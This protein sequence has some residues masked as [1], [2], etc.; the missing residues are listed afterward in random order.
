MNIPP[1]KN[2]PLYVCI[3]WH[4][5]QP[6]YKKPDSNEYIMPWVRLHAIKDYYDMLYEVLKYPE[7]KVTFN[8][9][10]SL[11]QQIKDYAENNVED[12]F[13]SVSKKEASLLTEDEKIFILKNFFS[14]NK[15]SM[16]EPYSRYKWLYEKRGID[17]T[18][19]VLKDKLK[20]FNVND[21]RDLQVW[22]NLAW[23]GNYLKSKN[24]IKNLL[25]K[26]RNFSESDKKIL[27]SE[28]E[29]LIGEIL[30]LYKKAFQ[31]NRI[32]ISTSPYF[33]P[34]LPLLFDIN[35]ARDSL[36]NVELPGQSF[37]YPEDAIYQVESA[38][39]CF[40][41]EFGKR[42]DG[43][44]PSEG[45]ISEE[46]LKILEDKGFKWV[47][48]DETV[49]KNS[50]VKSGI[51]RSEDKLLHQSKYIPY[52][53]KNASGI[54][55]FF[56]DLLLSDMV[57]FT[58]S[59]YNGKRAADDL[60]SRLLLIRKNLPE[61]DKKYVVPIILDGENAWE[62]YKNNGKEFFKYLYSNLSESPFLKCVSFSDYLKI[63]S[64][65]PVLPKV[66]AGSWIYGNFS[67][68]IG[69]KEKNK[70]W[71]FL[72]ITRKKFSEVAMDV[73][74]G[75]KKIDQYSLKKAFRN[76]LIAEGSDWFWWYG[77]DH[78]SE[79]EE[80]FDELFRMYLIQSY[81][82][83]NERIPE[84]FFEPIIRKI[85]GYEIQPP[86]ELIT[87]VLDGYITDYFEW[88]PAGFFTNKYTYTTMQ[89]VHNIF[90]GFYF[91]FDRENFYVRV[92]VPKE[93]LNDKKYPFVMIVNF[94]RPGNIQFKLIKDN[95]REFVK[96]F[97]EILDSNGDVVEEKD[98]NTFGVNK[99]VEI[100]I[101]F[102]EIG[103]RKNQNLE[104]SVSLFI[105]D[106]LAE[107]MPQSG[108]V[109][110]KISIDE[111]DKYYWIV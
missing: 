27:F 91:G 78:T 66:M 82:E 6:I 44:W 11:V 92:D 57:G 102:Y 15:E 96:F 77:E 83:M 18:S 97:K 108:Y 26:G 12:A 33:H 51:L 85:V 90:T 37:H 54:K 20:N 74:K 31:E 93:I 76:I 81:K 58:Y 34:I 39:K 19:E 62:F 21:Y 45:S 56:R 2:D 40:E 36:P 22:F 42:P 109:S 107:R 63:K 101:P 89:R 14:L 84:E 111:F 1:K 103:V 46:V 52:G 86:H 17:V 67:T 35:S 53:F 87:P 25:G 72:A 13:L 73:E 23:C 105:G 47:A 28:Q 41:N 10:P 43:I 9:V 95:K 49:L 75:V 64:T 8:L 88:L 38:I 7:I 5:H 48:T 3:L 65:K 29:K 70:A 99:I 24:S 30:P 16:I 4:M 68:W 69:Q 71:E 60:T 50:L 100:G 32:E 80:E 94:R 110:Q 79:Y 98:F 104:F 106:N 59:K 55:I 61:D